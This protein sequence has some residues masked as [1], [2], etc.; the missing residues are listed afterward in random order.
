M[1]SKDGQDNVTS[2]PR[3]SFLASDGRRTSSNRPPTGP[4]RPASG[5]AP[6]PLTAVVQAA[7]DQSGETWTGKGLSESPH[8]AQEEP[9]TTRAVS[10]GPERRG[11]QSRKPTPL[12]IGRLPT[13]E[14]A[15]PPSPSRARWEHI[16]QHVLPIPVRPVT[17]PSAQ[18]HL[19]PPQQ[20]HPLP[21]PRSQTPKPSRLARLGFRQVVEQAREVALDDTRKFAQ[22]LQ[23]VCWSIRFVAPERVKVE[24]E[25]ATMG[26]SLHLPFMSNASLTS[27]STPSV[28]SHPGKKQEMRRPPS[29]PTLA[30]AYRSAPSLK[31]LYHVLLHHATSGSGRSPTPSLPSE[32]QVLSTLLRPFMASERGAHIEGE[33]TIAMESF[34]II[35]R[36]WAPVDQVSVPTF[37]MIRDSYLSNY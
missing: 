4:R 31:P 30:T 24:R 33:R 21:P 1:A 8:I 18:P 19:T 3:S 23:R 29:M 27:T 22:E 17:P 14:E 2:S 34:D 36:T 5:M 10:P 15:I 35:I 25:P 28:D 13:P 12:N 32:L 6:R 20:T 11:K 16:R 7:E 9:W 26:S 37:P